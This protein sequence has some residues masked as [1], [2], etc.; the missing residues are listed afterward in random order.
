MN[1]FVV[2]HCPI[3]AAQ[4]LCDKHVTKMI[5]E[6]AQMLSTC[7]QVQGGTSLYKMVHKNHP[8]TVWTRETQSNYNWLINHGFALSDEFTRRFSG[9]HKSRAVIADAAKVKNRKLRPHGP[10]TPH[11]QC[12]P[13]QYKI[14]DDPVEAYRRYYV[15]EKLKFARWKYTDV[16]DWVHSIIQS[17][18]AAK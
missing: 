8:C 11:P 18:A 2:Q 14:P 3:R 5:L 6:T 15:G 17:R 13:E 9:I 7:I 16:P 10:L 12:M 1:I 4:D